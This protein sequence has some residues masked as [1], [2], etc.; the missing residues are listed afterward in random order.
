MTTEKD[1]HLATVRSI[2]AE[3]AQ[4]LDGMDYCLDWGQ[5]RC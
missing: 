1:T 5:M 4:V 3:L 2:Q